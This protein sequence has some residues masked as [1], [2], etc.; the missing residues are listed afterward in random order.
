MWD[1]IVGAL[2]Q[3][4]KRPSASDLR[5][6]TEDKSKCL[7]ASSDVRLADVWTEDCQDVDNQ[8]WFYNEEARSLQL[9]GSNNLC[10]DILAGSAN[11]GAKL[12]LWNCYD[13]PSQK[14]SRPMG[15]PS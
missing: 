8:K 1:H 2:N 10:L 12:T 9:V 11:N 6:H 4:W 15:T 13:G 5:I 3:S 14:W 7:A